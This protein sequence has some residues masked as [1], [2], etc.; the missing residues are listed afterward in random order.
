MNKKLGI[1]IIVAAIV[2]VA[3][4]AGCIEEEAPE[5]V[6]PTPT[7]T[8]TPTPTPTP[9]L[10]YDSSEVEEISVD[11]DVND[12]YTPTVSLSFYDKYDRRITNFNN[13]ETT[14]IVVLEDVFKNSIWTKSTVI[15]SGNEIP[16]NID[17]II[18]SIY[19]RDKVIRDCCY[20]KVE[21]LLPDGRI[22]KANIPFIYSD[23]IN[24]KQYIDG[25]EDGYDD[26]LRG[27][28]AKVS[29]NADKDYRDGYYDGYGDFTPRYRYWDVGG[30]KTIRLSPPISEQPKSWHPVNTFSG[31]EDKN[32][33]SF[34][35]RGE[36]WR[37]TYTV[38]DADPKYG[39]FYMSVYPKGETVGYVAHVSCRDT[40]CS[41]TIYIFKGTGNYYI[42][43]LAANL[44]SWKLEVEDYY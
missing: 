5:A 21:V 18:V 12:Y 11:I 34:A 16:E 24:I 2:M 39:V 29:I 1:G 10:N 30:H 14:V 7:P 9:P 27:Y 20:L 3:M 43:V 37:V 33:T 6:Y 42:K 32:T 35:I 44:D 38:N 41:N 36:V 26:A 19:E 31:K 13:G 25:Y 22:A 17:A 8:F 40:P 28:S 23:Q 15:A 4:F